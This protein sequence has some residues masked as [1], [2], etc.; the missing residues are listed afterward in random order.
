M[1]PRVIPLRSGDRVPEAVPAPSR[2][3]RY[4]VASARLVGAVSLLAIGGIHIE[5]YAVADYRVIPTIGTLFLLNF[6]GGTVLGLYM[7]VP[8]GTSAGRRRRLADTVV[9]LGGLGIAATSLAALFISEHTPLFGFMEHGYRIEILIA[10][11]SEA[12][13]TVALAVFLILNRGVA[14]RSRPAGRHR[15]AAGAVAPLSSPTKP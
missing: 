11:I 13:G 9:A 2:A 6:I 1:H 8:A 7:L 3:R 12:V 5:Q 10:I 15:G 14:P 4:T